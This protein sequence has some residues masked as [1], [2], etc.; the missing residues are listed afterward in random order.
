M[1]RHIDA[2]FRRDGIADHREE[3]FGFPGVA[4]EE[5]D[6]HLA[7]LG[8]RQDGRRFGIETRHQ[9]GIGIPLG[10]QSQGI[11]EFGLARLVSHFQH[12]LTAQCGEALSE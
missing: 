6:L 2:R 1:R 5:G 10:D 12:N 7:R 9:D 3:P 4:A 11:V 8:R